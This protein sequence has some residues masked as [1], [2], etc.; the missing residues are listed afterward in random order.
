M[1]KAMLIKDAE[2]K[3]I[4]AASFKKLND[5]IFEHKKNGYFCLQIISSK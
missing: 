2:L 4:S 5:L 1:K 3:E